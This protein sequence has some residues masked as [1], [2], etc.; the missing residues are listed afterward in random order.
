M[1]NA[2]EFTQAVEALSVG[3]R[4][5]EALYLHREALEVTSSRLY[6]FALAVS[7][8]LKV[9]PNSWNIV[10]LSR[11]QFAISLLDYPTFYTDAY[12][13]LTTSISIDLARLNHRIVDYSDS[14][15]P[16]ILH[17]KELMV[18]PAC[19]HHSNF[20]MIT[21]EGEVAGLY[22]NTRLIGFKSSWK[23]HIAKHGY[24]LV[25]G[26][27]FRASMLP[28][29]D[30][31]NIDRHKTAL[32]RHALSA[33]MKT[34][35]KHGFLN[36]ELSLFDYGCGRGDDLRELQSHGLDALGW[37]PNHF[38]EGEK[39]AAAIVNLGFVLNV[40]EDKHERLEALMG[41]WDL[42][43]KLLVVGV[44][45]ANDDFIAQFTAYKDGVITSRNTFQKYYQQAEI[46]A[47][48]ERT[49]DE[50]AIAVAPGIFY[51][52]RDKDEE[53]RFLERRYRRSTHWKQLSSPPGLTQGD[54][55]RL[56][57]AKHQDLF[58]AFW[59]AVLE[60]GRI[61][62]ADEFEQFDDL[63]SIA[64]SSAK[65]LRI[66]LEIQG[67]E[68]YDQA[69]NQRT[70][71]LLLFFAMAQF[72]KRRPYTQLSETL[73]RDIKAFFID[74]HTALQQASAIL[75]QIADTDAIEQA[76]IAAHRSLPA[77]LLN[78]G[79][80]L[81][82][83]KTHLDALPLLLRVY[84]GAGLQLYGDLDDINLIKIHI[85]SGKLTLTGYDD[86]EKSVPFL[87][88]RVKIKMAEQDIDFFDYVNEAKRPP[89]LNR[90]LYIHQG[91][92]NFHKQQN[93]DKRLAKLLG[94]GHSEEVLLTRAAFERGLEEECKRIRG[95]HIVPSHGA[96]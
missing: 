73:K 84:V 64:G 2:T 68:E 86:F 47:Y 70:Q 50:Q 51:I 46:R 35:A 75:Y 76:C 28:E 81:I 22:E 87:K 94:T 65:S 82:F 62:Q 19:P 96:L 95:F 40:I 93:F 49:L 92:D 7:G 88:E 91:C 12:P 67:R 77:S 8:A 20:K 63:K 48:I 61:P 27:L 79:H 57:V 66:L 32:V 36:G 43:E 42:A 54:K 13:A 17:R 58:A 52:F 23:A 55:A 56:L 85:T 5:P 15:N 44:M 72:E 10:K 11:R 34:L 53:Q 33:P 83:H 90:S 31:I 21:E 1:I 9:D 18:L 14:D 16:P 25:D 41:A 45:L 6:Q 69:V 4:L 29:D 39:T 30:G 38:P 78:P 59:Q 26:R 74:H 24:V 60:L 71:D 89:L 3:K 80:S 37:D